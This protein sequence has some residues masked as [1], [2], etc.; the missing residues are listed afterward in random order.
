MAHC[1]MFRSACHGYILG[2]EINKI[3]KIYDCVVY[4]LA[5]IT[6]RDCTVARPFAMQ[7]NHS[8]LSTFLLLDDYRKE[9]Y[10]GRSRISRS[11]VQIHQE[12]VRF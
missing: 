8:R 5:T 2:K 12:G 4:F 1:L 3:L 6:V 7:V 9:V 10:R 11:G